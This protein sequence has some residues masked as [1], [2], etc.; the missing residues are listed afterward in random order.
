VSV[1]YRPVQWNVKKIGDASGIA[2]GIYGAAFV[3]VGIVKLERI[4]NYIFSAIFVMLT[5]KFHENR[6]NIKKS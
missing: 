1:K 6:C 4:E 2:K 3:V 5:P